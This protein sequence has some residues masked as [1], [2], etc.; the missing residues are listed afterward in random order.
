MIVSNRLSMG[1][2]RLMQAK[3]MSAPGH[4]CLGVHLGVLIPCM[5]RCFEWNGLAI[6]AVVDTPNWSRLVDTKNV[7]VACGR[8]GPLL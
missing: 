7:S 2:V 6:W 3:L 8:A 1:C 4:I 5:C